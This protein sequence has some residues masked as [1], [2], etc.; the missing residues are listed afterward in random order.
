MLKDQIEDVG[1]RPWHERR[2]AG[3][4]PNR[5]LPR[6]YLPLQHA[7]TSALIFPSFLTRLP[8]IIALGKPLNAIVHGPHLRILQLLAQTDDKRITLIRH[9]NAELGRA[10]L[11]CRHKAFC[12]LHM[13]RLPL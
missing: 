9:V 12:G 1:Y 10:S 6:K 3:T 5:E 2:A 8:R 11:E 13:P 4:S 7:S